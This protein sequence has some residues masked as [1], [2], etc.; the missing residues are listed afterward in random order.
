MVQIT[1]ILGAVAIL[2]SSA[3]AA[4]AIRRSQYQQQ[5]QQQ[6]EEYT[7]E[8]VPEYAPEPEK[9]VLDTEVYEA[10][11]YTTPAYSQETYAPEYQQ[12]EEVWNTEPVYEYT[13]P[14]AHDTTTV[15]EQELNETW[16]ETT[17]S[18]YAYPTYGS[19]SS[20][21]GASYDDCVSQCVAKYGEPPKEYMPE[22]HPTE[23]IEGAVHTVMVAPM[24]GVL[25]YY[26]FALNA[27]VGDTVRYIWSTPANHTATLSSELSICNKSALADERSFV[28]GIKSG[29]EGEQTFDVKVTTDEPQFFYCSVQQHCEKGMWGIINPKS[30]F[31]G[32]ETVGAKM[33]DWVS[34]NPDLGAAWAV[35]HETTKD[36]PADTWGNSISLAGVPETE[37]NNLATNVVWTRAMLAANPGTIENGRGAATPDGSP[38]SLVGDLNTFLSATTNDPNAVAAPNGSATGELPNPS[39]V[40][41]E[42][43]A[44][45]GASHT[46]VGV[47][48]AALVGAASFFLL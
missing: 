2:S 11:A 18:D 25:R 33:N 48:V 12:E 35:V 36:T 27:T 44:T 39:Q 10:P 34:A 20:E 4:P 6:Q 29:A 42:L 24:A 31:G 38:L 22:E 15:E 28:S 5:Q 45:S 41:A 13:P 17:T 23:G 7:P 26:P 21:W 37:Y 8:Y 14:A 47:W 19:G 16:Y 46:T 3:F 40:A 32:I 43:E 9:V 30:E 1:S